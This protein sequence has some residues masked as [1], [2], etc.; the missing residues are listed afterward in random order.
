[1]DI[2]KATLQDPVLSKLHDWVM[3][4]WPEA[5]LKILDPTILIGMNLLLNKI[6]FFG[7]QG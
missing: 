5:V 6:A 7:A 3:M 4:G 1:M 2:G